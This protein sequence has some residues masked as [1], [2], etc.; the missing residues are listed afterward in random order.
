MDRYLVIFIT[1]M[2]IL[3]INY[4]AAIVYSRMKVRDFETKEGFSSEEK[5]IADST[6][7]KWLEP[8]ELFDDFYCQVYDQLTQSSIRL[9]AEVGLALHAFKA[10]GALIESMTFLDAGCGSGIATAALAKLN[11]KKVIA[12]DLSKSMI[13]RTKKITLEDSTLTQAQK[14]LIEFREGNL[15]DA[16]IVKP[17]EITNAI[18]LYFVIYYMRDIE[19]FFRNMFVWVRPGGM[20]AIEVV[21]KYK[22]DPML[23]SASPFVAFSMQKYA[24]ERIRKSE[25]TF[26]GFKYEGVFDLFDPVAEFRE[27]FR[28]KDGSVRRQKHILTMPAISEIVSAAQVVGW[29][30]DSYVDLTAVGF[31][32]AYLLLFTHP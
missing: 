4:W 27:T 15:L 14:D 30:Y 3:F 21:N 31:E 5:S 24:K 16:G 26:D 7:V 8:P 29:K 9:Q 28:F 13:Q 10:K 20:M 2:I 18:C 19:A 6:V 25:V 12:V 1:V 32:Y 22:F 11:A 17:G 23:D